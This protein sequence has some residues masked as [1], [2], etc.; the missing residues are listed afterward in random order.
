MVDVHNLIDSL[1]FGSWNFYSCP[2]LSCFWLK[3]ENSDFSNFISFLNHG[4]I[5]GNQIFLYM[6]VICSIYRFVSVLGS[7]ES[8]MPLHSAIASARLKSNIAFDSTC[9]SCLSQVAAVNLLLSCL[10]VLLRSIVSHGVEKPA[11]Q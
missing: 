4:F 6:I 5:Y 10:L 3:M 8:M 11:I 9:W 1:A 2:L 7:L